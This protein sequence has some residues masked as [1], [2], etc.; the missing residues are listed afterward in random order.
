MI[1]VLRFVSLFFVIGCGTVSET[2]NS[3]QQGFA[4]DAQ[5]CERE[6]LQNLRAS[7]PNPQPGTSNAQAL[8]YR[9]MYLTCMEVR[10]WTGMR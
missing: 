6:T 10:G 4:R 9:Q 7:Y 5:Q 8:A 1:R 3:N 2:P